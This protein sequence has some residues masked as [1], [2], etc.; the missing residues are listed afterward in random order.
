M[1]VNDNNQ[2]LHN[3]TEI[4]GFVILETLH[5]TDDDNFLGQLLIKIFNH[6]ISQTD[7]IFQPF[8]TIFDQDIQSQF[9]HNF[10]DDIQ[11][12]FSI[13][14]LKSSITILKRLRYSITILKRFPA[15]SKPLH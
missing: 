7:T 2:N 3:I 11:S 14:I 13:T 5:H 4:C 10:F 15:L 8:M 12:Q 6:N 9:N 1:K